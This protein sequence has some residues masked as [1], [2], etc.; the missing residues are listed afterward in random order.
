MSQPNVPDPDGLEPGD[1]EVEWRGDADVERPD[2]AEEM[3]TEPARGEE[4]ETGGA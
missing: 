3:G 4:A 2:D 1:V